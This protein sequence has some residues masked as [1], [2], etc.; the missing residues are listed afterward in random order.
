MYS[1][2]SSSTGSS[3]SATVSRTSQWRRVIQL[4]LGLTVI[5]GIVLVATSWTSQIASEPSGIP[6]A[7]AGSERWVGPMEDQLEQLDPGAFDVTEVVDAAEAE[8]LIRDHKVYGAIVLNRPPAVP[9]ILTA[10]AASPQATQ[11]L[12]KL[13]GELAVQANEAASAAQIGASSASE[14]L[15]VH[16]TDVVPLSDA[17]PNGSGFS[18]AL[19]PLVLGGIA[20]GA[21]MSLLVLGMRRRITGLAIYSVAAGVVLVT[22][23]QGWY[24]M[25]QGNYALNALA[26]AM[27]L[28]ALGTFVIGM[29]ARLPRLGIAIAAAFFVFVANPLA[30][31][32]GGW[33]LILDPWGLIG[34]W[35]PEGAGLTLLRDFSYFPTAST[36]FPWVVLIVWSILGLLLAQKA[37]VVGPAPFKTAHTEAAVP[38]GPLMGFH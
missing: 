9:E 5:I 33:R 15:V 32:M 12:T 20:G 4:S 7:V 14:P 38:Q 25:L 31:A 26:V 21:V 2:P 1:Q 24:R 16:I 17:D 23:F 22:I 18:I 19:L 6:I 35:T 29:H 36:V 30:G 37:R 13:A 27:I 11:M 8:Q 34:Q 28:F 10:S 3:A